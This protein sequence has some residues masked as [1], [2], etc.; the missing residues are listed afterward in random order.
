M[1]KAANAKPKK[2]QATA[3]VAPTKF[4]PGN[5][6]A[7]SKLALVTFGIAF[8]KHLVTYKRPDGFPPNIKVLFVDPGYCRTPGMR[9]WLTGGSLLGLL[10][11]LITYPV[12][13]LVLKSPDMGAQSFLYA[14]MEE[15]FSRTEGGVLVKECKQRDYIRT[16]VLDELKQKMLWE[17]SEQMVQEA[18]KRGATDRA[19]AKKEEEEKKEEKKVEEKKNKGKQSKNKEKQRKNKGNK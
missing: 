14:A 9:R 11:Y 1:S 8:Q 15:K 10:A 12:W 4:S 18:E 7:T 13:W 16:D 2:S 6:Y 19:K 5:A 17:Y 3:A